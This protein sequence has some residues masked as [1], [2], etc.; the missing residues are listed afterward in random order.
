MTVITV[1]G[2]SL[3]EGDKKIL[4][5]GE[6][7]MTVLERLPFNSSMIKSEEFD[8]AIMIVEDGP[9][10]GHICLSKSSWVARTR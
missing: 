6:N 4:A 5:S 3:F 10:I 8:L 1:T 7:L 9:R 2:S